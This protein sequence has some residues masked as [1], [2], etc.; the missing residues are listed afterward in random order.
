MEKDWLTSRK[1]WQTVRQLRKRKWGLAQAVFSMGGELLTQTGNI[2]EQWIEHFEELLNLTNMSS[3]KEAELEDSGEA[4]PI[5]L[6]EGFTLPC[7][8]EYEAVGIRVIISKSEVMVLYWKMVDYS[9]WVESELV[10]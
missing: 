1:F 6:V 10:L 8:V 7:E 2:V 5:S 4:S 9:I 3:V